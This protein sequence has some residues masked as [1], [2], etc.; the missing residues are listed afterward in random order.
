MFDLHNDP[1]ELTD[2]S[3]DRGHGEIVRRLLAR[4]G[5]WQRRTG[6]RWMPAPIV[7]AMSALPIDPT[8]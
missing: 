1:D 2:L 6:D 3:G 7:E 5:E 8:A 4:L